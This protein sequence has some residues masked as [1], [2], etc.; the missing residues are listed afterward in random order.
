MEDEQE[1]P[2]V[3]LG[4]EWVDLKQI[5][6]DLETDT[7]PD[8][9]IW[10]ASA[11]TALAPD[12]GTVRLVVTG[13]FVRSAKDRMADF[14]KRDEFD[15]VRNGGVVGAKT[16]TLAD[17]R[18]DVLFPAWWFVTD[19]TTD[20]E[21]AAL[22]QLAK[23]TLVHEAQH[24]SMTQSGEEFEPPDGEPWARTNFLAI[25]GQVLDEYRAEAGVGTELRAG[26]E[27]WEPI[28]I[29]TTLRENNARIV[30]EYQVH[31]DVGRLS[32]EIGTEVH[33]AWKL[34]AYVVAAGLNADRDCASLPGALTTHP[35]WVRMVGPHWSRFV[36]I[37]TSMPSGTERVERPRHAL[38]V[39]ELA[40]EL[41]AWLE[42]LGYRW[43]DLEGGNSEFLIVKWD[44]LA[45]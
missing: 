35:M 42:T 40:V 34:L 5:G 31:R 3:G 11:L 4:L 19:G 20:E 8:L 32:Y 18:I 14:V 38:A 1:R 30:D 16:L 45:R 9:M 10:C 43:R 25:A 41:A 2:H 26:E 23:R 39:T 7:F 27:R 21:R 33:T 15:L 29:L 17:G 24:V 28:T 6:V 13:D 36:E 12:P 37:L 22:E 44:L